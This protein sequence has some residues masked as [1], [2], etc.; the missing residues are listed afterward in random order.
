MLW[1]QGFYNFS[2]A[3]FRWISSSRP[4]LLSAHWVWEIRA[5]GIGPGRSHSV[6]SG[7]SKS[8]DPSELLL[9][10]LHSGKNNLAFI[11]SFSC[12]HVQRN[13]YILL[14]FLFLSF[15][16]FEPVTSY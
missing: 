7:Y 15:F 14:S 2:V 5:C 9:S 12:P 10:H 6:C 3:A 11:I 16:N 1:T 13:L 8:Q 4:L